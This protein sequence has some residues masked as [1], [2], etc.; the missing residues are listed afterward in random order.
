M[1]SQMGGGIA[2]LTCAAIES[3]TELPVAWWYGWHDTGDDIRANFE[4]AGCGAVPSSCPSR[5]CDQCC[6]TQKR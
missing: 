1:C 2:G 3:A 6:G 5:H 4:G